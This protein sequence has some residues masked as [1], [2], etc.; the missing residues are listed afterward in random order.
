MPWIPANS[1]HAIDRALIKFEFGPLPAKAFEKVIA[2]VKDDCVAEG[3]SDVIS[4]QNAPT[5]QLIA[6][7]EGAHVVAQQAPVATSRSFRRLSED[8][9]VL[10]EVVCSQTVLAFNVNHYESWVSI[11]EKIEACLTRGATYI[12]DNIHN[13]DAI[14]FEYWD[15]FVQDEQGQEALLNPDTVLIPPSFEKVEGSWHSHAG[16]FHLE[17]ERRTLMNVNVDVISARDAAANKLVGAQLPAGISSLCRI[18]S[19]AFVTPEGGAYKDFSDCIAAAN[20]AHE[21]LKSAIGNV[22][23]PALANR[24]NLKAKAFE[25]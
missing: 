20:N 15:R 8:G 14:R 24:I 9:N 21:R 4:I 1:V 25:I 13:V 10:E 12:M 3:F 6:D 19:L 17:H 11:A 5:F 2:L 18:Y 16:F 7:G 22:I 23:N